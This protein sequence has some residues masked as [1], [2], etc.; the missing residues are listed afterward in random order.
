[1]S[2]ARNAAIEYAHDGQK[3]FLNQ[4][5]EFSAIPSVSTDPAH[6]ADMEKA[7][8]WLVSKLEDLGVDNVK[9]YPTEGHPVVYGQFSAA[10]PQAPTVL[11]YGHYDVQPAEP[12]DKWDSPPFE[13]TIRGDNLFARGA[14]DMKGQVMATLNAVEAS[15]RRTI[16]P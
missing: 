9:Q 12:L 16:C 1:M 14:T 5:I 4:L 3:R 7:A 6:K 15:H 10:N 13:P 8:G 11:V 2:D